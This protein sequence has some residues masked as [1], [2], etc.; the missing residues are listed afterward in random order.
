MA[1]QTEWIEEPHILGTTFDSSATIGELNSVML[2]YISAA[3]KSPIYL[4]LDFND[5]NV[6]NRILSLPS[7]L[8]VV[9]HGNTRW[10]CVVKPEASSSYMTK[11][12]TRDRVK[13]F[14][15]RESAIS[16]LRAMLRIDESEG[17]AYNV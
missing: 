6:P 13:M 10:L 11:L 14:R 16:F 2:Q 3:Q 5:I 1:F 17:F 8:Q 9:N 12:L 15:D 4:L 7:L